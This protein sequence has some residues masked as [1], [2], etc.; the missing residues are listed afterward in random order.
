MQREKRFSCRKKRSLPL[1]QQKRNGVLET[2]FK[3]SLPIV[4]D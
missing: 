1:K 4:V 3:A 2:L